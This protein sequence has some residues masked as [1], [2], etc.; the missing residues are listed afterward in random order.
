LKDGSED[1]PDPPKLSF[2][3]NPA[4]PGGVFFLGGA[5]LTDQACLEGDALRE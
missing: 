2:A 3:E 4:F 1:P 5:E